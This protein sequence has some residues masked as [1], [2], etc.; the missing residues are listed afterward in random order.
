ME[1]KEKMGFML[2]PFEFVMGPQYVELEE[3]SFCR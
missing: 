2:N 3:L 1:G